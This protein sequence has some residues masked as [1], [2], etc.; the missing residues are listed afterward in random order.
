VSGATSGRAARLGLLAIWSVG[1]LAY[2]VS[3]TNR[4]SLSAL[5]VDAAHHF[6]IDPVTLSLF[7]VMQLAVYGALQIPVG[8]LLDRFGPRAVLTGGMLVLAVSQVVLALAPSVPLAIIARLLLGAG[9]AA[10]FPSLLRVIGIRFPRRT[11][12]VVVQVTGLLGQF[13]QIVSVIPF[14]FLVHAQG[15]MRGFL[16]LA[17]TTALCGVLTWVVVRERGERSTERIDVMANVRTAWREPGTRLGFWTHF[18]T[19]F[20]GNAFAV[21]WGYPFLVNAQGVAPRTAQLLFTIYVLFGLVAGP[22][23]GALS[24]RFAAHR[25]R[26]VVALVGVQIV[27]WVAVLAFPGPAPVAFL[28]VLAVAMCIGGPSSMLAFDFA[29]EHNPPMRLSTATG[30]VNSA[31]FLSSVL[32]LLAI[33]AV[34][35]LLDPTNAYGLTAFRAAEL[36]QVPLWAIGIVMVLRSASAL[37]RRSREFEPDG[38]S[39]NPDAVGAGV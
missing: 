23:I 39:R 19:P 9:D 30:I 33:G 27:A 13:G 22:A 38:A 2:V 15:W 11:A 20:A 36:I 6:G 8:L 24:A 7:A 14:A 17:A 29:R 28:V 12:P 26:L 4:T 16:L 18:T 3:I 21:L 25:T 34:L 10:I 31:G 37:R 5:G 1:V 35:T 32:A